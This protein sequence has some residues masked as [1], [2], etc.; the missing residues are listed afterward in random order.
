VGAH[1]VIE[2]EELSLIVEALTPD[3]RQR[4]RE[5]GAV[6]IGGPGAEALA[7]DLG[8]RLGAAVRERGGE[9]L[10]LVS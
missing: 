1:A 8:L 9:A 4:F 10:L 7:R 3:G 5:R 2:G 6:N